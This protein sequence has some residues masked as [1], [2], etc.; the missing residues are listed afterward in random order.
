MTNC[1]VVSDSGWWCSSPFLSHRASVCPKTI[2][3]VMWPVRLDTECCYVPTVVV[4]IYLLAFLHAFVLLGWQEPGQATGAHSVTWIRSYDCW[5][6]PQSHQVPKNIIYI[7][8]SSGPNDVAKKKGTVP[9]K[10]EHELI[11]LHS[12]K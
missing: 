3:V 2:C 1:P 6:N 8:A 7:A 4:P 5:F 11:E 9:V 12:W 10:A